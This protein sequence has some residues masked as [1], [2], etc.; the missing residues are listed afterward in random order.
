MGRYKTL[1]RSLEGY[2]MEGGDEGSELEVWLVTV[3][4]RQYV[5]G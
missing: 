2:W 5:D 1:V 3:R 4:V